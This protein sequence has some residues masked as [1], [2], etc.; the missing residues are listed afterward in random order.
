[1]AI[2]LQ[3]ALASPLGGLWLVHAIWLWR[4]NAVGSVGLGQV[5]HLAA[6]AGPLNLLFPLLTINMFL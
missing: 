4:R 2:L 5:V 1:M 6:D 3:G